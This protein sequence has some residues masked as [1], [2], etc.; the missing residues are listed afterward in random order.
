MAPVWRVPHWESL[1]GLI[2]GFFGRRGGLSEG[3]FSSLN[4]SER[5]GDHGP[6]L[7][8]NW[9]RVGAELRGLTIVTMR[10][11]HGTSV[12]RVPDAQRRLGEADGL[13]T[14]TPGVGLGVLTADC[15]PIL[16]VSAARRVA[17]AV[18]A[19]WRGTASG[20]A[21]AA[22]LHAARE[23]SVDP[24]E[25]EVALGPSAGGCCFEIEC[26]IYDRVER[27]W[28]AMSG[29]WSGTGPRGKLDLRGVNRHI[30]RKAGVD[31][32]K[33]FDVGPCTMC[34]TDDFFS[35]RR[36]AGKTGRQLAAIGWRD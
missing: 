26:A 15:V 30:L 34:R 7:A 12:L 21:R 17:L 28:G 6:A 32:E 25:I 2:H 23:Y 22:V 36:S 10:Q 9:N 19:G 31:P 14:D 18:H 8:G 20:I 4:L 33:I 35:H 5:V 27:D 13:S 29:V 11:V 24:A 1:P 16:M 3:S